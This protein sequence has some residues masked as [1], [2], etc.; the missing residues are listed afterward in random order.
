[1]KPIPQAVGLA[2]VAAGMSVVPSLVPSSASAAPPDLVSRM[3][4]AASGTTAVS[5]AGATG[6]VGFIRSSGDLLPSKTAPATL[7]GAKSKASSYL[8]KYAKAF[9]ASTDQLEDDGVVADET[10]WTVD[11]TQQYDGVPVFGSKLRLHVDPSGAL[12]SVNGYVAPDLDLS[13]TPNVSKE[14]AIAR[15]LGMVKTQPAGTEGAKVPAAYV[16]GLQVKKADLMVYKRG[17]IQGVAGDSL[18]AWVLEVSNDKTVRET[19]VL[20]ARTGKPV[21]RF[22]MIADVLDRK[23]IEAYDGEQDPAVVWTEGDP[24]P[25]SKLGGDLDVDQQNELLGTAEAY[26]FYKNT[27]GRDSYDGAGAQMVTVNNDPGIDCPN[28]NW[29]GVSTNYCDGVSSDDTVAHEWSH[30]YTEKTSGLLYQWQS[31]AMN[32]AMSDIFG[33]TVDMMNAR[34]NTTDVDL[35][36]NGTIDDGESFTEETKRTDGNCSVGTPGDLTVDITAPASAAGP[37]QNALKP[38]WSR[39]YPANGIDLEVVVATDGTDDAAGDTSTTN[40]CTAFTNAAAVAGKLA[41]VDRG[42]CAF[43]DKIDNAV[44]SG[45][46]GI[47][48]GNNQ[49]GS[50]SPAG[51]VE[52]PFYGLTVTQADGTRIKTAG[53]VTMHIAESLEGRDQTGRWLSGEDDPAMGGAI[54][55]MWDPTCYGDPGKVSDEEYTCSTDDNGGVHTN[56]GVVNHTYALLV[57]GGSYNGVTVAGI[58]LDKAAHL[59]WQAQTHYLTPTSKFA[60]LADGLVASCNDL[61][62]QQLT[63]VDLGHPNEDGTGGQATPALTDAVS[64]ADCQAVNAVIQ[65]TELRADPVQCNFQPMLEKAGIGCGDNFTTTTAYSED[66]EDGLAGWT[67][68]EGFLDCSDDEFADACDAAGLPADYHG[69]VSFPWETTTQLPVVSPGQSV[70]SAHPA[71]RVAVGPDPAAGGSC[72][73]DDDDWSARN[74]LIS[75]AITVPGGPSV[76]FQFDH[77]VATE[78]LFDGGNVKVSVNGGDFEVIPNEAYLYNA[79][80]QD[81]STLGDGN[82]NPLAGETAFTGTDGGE[83]SGSWGTSYVDLKALAAPGDSVRFKFDIGRDGCNGVDGWYVDNVKVTVCKVASGVT[84]AVVPASA[85]YPQGG[86]VNV[87]V[88]GTDPSGTVT[89]KEGVTTLGSATLSANGTASVALPGGLAV[90]GH[91]LT[92]AYS[93]DATNAP[94]T[95]T[96]AFT[97]RKAAST[98]SVQA[99]HSVRKGRKATLTVRVAANGVTPTGPVVVRRAGKVVAH[100]NL[101]GGVATLKVRGKKPGRM[102]LRVTYAG[103]AVVAGSSE[104]VTIRVRA[105]R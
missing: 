2:L 92:V 16:A 86:S 27:F 54:R 3:K 88:A 12:T 24:W 50:I 11:Y 4:A 49:A 25:T 43:Q 18:L 10:G 95:T 58:G 7:A 94:G 73:G 36:D 51:Q 67:Q 90:G 15:A 44:A 47:V 30:A 69:G 105:K 39:A 40:G 62:G 48:I 76:R 100:G 104:T 52:D 96:V 37:C 26:W 66:F 20:D 103:S 57:D 8:A 17:A 85:A 60:D 32:E 70:T 56:S 38:S 78:V 55:D 63:K 97:V 93:G 101:Q 77:Y 98:M 68:D 102:H 19:V 79:P 9:G 64:D 6:K 42:L 80:G 13:V 65:A 74:G 29:N 45:A 33:E 81:L 59:F 46:A 89:V 21:N 22:S 1:L 83:P 91:S 5:F 28:A 53:S 14:T 72:A 61:R 82:T 23:L 87:T 75:P 31:G 99:P 41:Y 35:D 84:A 34:M 71:G